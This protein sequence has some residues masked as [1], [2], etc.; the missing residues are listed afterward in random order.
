MGYHGVQLF[1]LAVELDGLATLFV[2]AGVVFLVGPLR[3]VLFG[4]FLEDFSLC[5]RVPGAMHRECFPPVI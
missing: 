2:A 4:V 1:I 3:G 5:H